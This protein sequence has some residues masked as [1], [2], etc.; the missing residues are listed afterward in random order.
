MA[1]C[2]F[3]PFINIKDPFLLRMSLNNIYELLINNY[4]RDK[5]FA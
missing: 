1:K 3:I 2:A 4:Y 5:V